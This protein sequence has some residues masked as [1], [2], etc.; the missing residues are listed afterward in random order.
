MKET[1][2]PVNPRQS[3]DEIG[4]FFFSFLILYF[5]LPQNKTKQTNKTK[6]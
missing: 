5:T 6:L 4:G 2:F 3:G 1:E